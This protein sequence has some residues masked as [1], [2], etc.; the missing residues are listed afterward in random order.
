[1]ARPSSRFIVLPSQPPLEQDSIGTSQSLENTSVIVAPA[2]L[3]AGAT[4]ALTLSGSSRADRLIGTSRNDTLTGLGG[5][6]FLDAGK[7]RDR[8][9]GGS[10]NDTYVVDNKRDKVIERSRGGTD[11]IKASVSWTLGSHVEKLTLTGRS[12]LKGTGNSLSNTITGNSKNNTLDGKKGADKLIGGKG[13][14]TYIV[15]TAKDRI[16][17]KSGQGTDTVRASVNHTL[18]SHVEKLVL[19]G[20][21]SNGVGNT[22]GNT[23]TDNGRAN[24][25]NG[26][27][28]NDRLYGGAGNDTLL[29]GTGADIMVG[30]SGNDVY[31]VD[32]AGDV[33]AEGA[34]S[35]TD[36]VWSS[37][38]H[39]LGAYVENLVLTGRALSGTGNAQ[40]NR[41]TGNAG[42]NTLDG[43][44][45][46]DILVGGSGNDVYVVDETGDQ[47]V[48]AEGGGTD[49]VRAAIDYTLGSSLE[50]LVLTGAA[51]EGTGNGL[52]NAIADN[53]R[54]NTLKG[55][56]GNDTLDGGEGADVLQGGEGDDLYLI[57][58][59]NDEILETFDGG[60]DSVEASIDHVLGDNIERLTLVGAALV[61]T[62][63]AHDNALVGN[64]LG[65]SLAGGE[66]NDTLNGGEGAD[67]LAG[68]ND[69]DT[70]LIGDTDGHDVIVESADAGH[71]TVQATID[72]TIGDHV[73]HL[74]LLRDATAGTGNAQ[75]NRITGNTFLA[76]SLSG[77]GGDD[78]LEGGLGDDTLIGGTGRDS[79]VG[80]VGNGVYVIDG[81]ADDIID[82]Q[83]GD[84]DIDTVRTTL[85]NYTVGARIEN[86][87]IQNDSEDN[88]A[89]GND[90]AND[91]TTSSKN[92]VLV[93]GAGNDTLR[94]GLG[95]DSYHIHG[96]DGDDVV[97]EAENA[98]R[99]RVYARI[100]YVLPENVEELILET[101]DGSGLQGTGN[102]LDNTLA[103]GQ[104]NDT[105]YGGDGNDYLRGS[106]AL[107]NSG[108]DSLV[109]G[110]G[111]DTY[112]VDRDD[113][114]VVEMADEGTD[115]VRS[116]A[117]N[118][119]LPDHVEN[120]T[121]IGTSDNN[122]YGNVLTGNSGCNILEGKNGNDT[123]DG[124]GGNDDL[125]G[126]L[127]DDVYVIDSS[128][129]LTEN[130]DQGTDTVRASFTYTLRENF[131]NLE[132]TGIG[133][134]DGTGNDANNR[135]IGNSG[136]NIL[137]GMRGTDTL[138]GGA[139][140]DVY[141]IE[142]PDE[143]IIET[144]GI[145]TLR[146]GYNFGTYDPQNGLTRTFFLHDGIENLT[147]TGG[148][149]V[150][151][152][153][154]LN[155]YILGNDANNVLDGIGSY[156]SR[157]T[158]N[159]GGGNDI[160]YG[161]EGPTTFEF[162]SRF[163]TDRI[164]GFGWNPNPNDLNRIDLSAC[165]RMSQR[166]GLG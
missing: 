114:V 130:I 3:A 133:N 15:D 115:L 158:L 101:L 92:D 117:A 148:T 127:G 106:V 23:I 51:V 31:F 91:I 9:T 107:G 18:G 105:L 49:T 62:G 96:G 5:S 152:G 36:T 11:T 151:V 160:L 103:G 34:V 64:A 50:H 73:E 54:A 147:L 42:H 102:G 22:L 55:E 78:T 67:T 65:N 94:G 80:G 121:L 74:V 40:I 122:G 46:A 60:S 90:L 120:L 19:T 119:T 27:A 89:N 116:G 45:G 111:D 118:F 162:S 52:D 28:G 150:G 86:L 112:T 154:E 59:A 87:V 113:E 108:R 145:D 1:M 153:N 7:G 71:D 47:V 97:I 8:M 81:D 85:R 140:N 10:G 141:T 14:D 39:V 37:I 58:D 83:G 72:Y 149:E 136:D 99:D 6:D 35:G 165:L 137:N 57:D 48:E 131:E 166:V 66:G 157:D 29:G 135:I 77:A 32:H 84:E 53:A 138:I 38:S 126:G 109:G 63:N 161:S 16:T 132:L 95:D 25:L 69:D 21:A 156:S 104:G 33:V 76:S 26:Q 20:S 100:D 139:G 88:I 159:G 44:A 75:N 134:I 12:K 56:A 129:W 79:L 144:W 143:V 17:E 68:G 125:R 155:N 123:L 61:G 82:E 128:D 163:G 146:A 142:S 98:G 41:I 24:Y 30:S 2:R 164:I 93:G 110:D 43:G 70:Y 13:H 124:G 4:N